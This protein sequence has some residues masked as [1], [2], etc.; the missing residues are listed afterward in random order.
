MEFVEFVWNSG[1]GPVPK[2]V[3]IYG[4]WDEYTDPISTIYDGHQRFHGKILL[5]MPG[6]FYYYFTVDG[7]EKRENDC[8]FKTVITNDTEVSFVSTNRVNVPK[9]TENSAV[10]TTNNPN[11]QRFAHFRTGVMASCKSLHSIKTDYHKLQNDAKNSMNTFQRSMEEDQRVTLSKLRDFMD[12]C[13]NLNSKY[14][15][16]VATNRKHFDKIQE[17]RG[18]IRVYARS[19]PILPIDGDS[20]HSVV[21]FMENQ[22]VEVQGKE[23]YNGAQGDG[24]RFEFDQIFDPQTNQ[25]T[26]YENVSGFVKSVMNGYNCCIFAYGQTGSGKTFTMQGTETNPGINIRALRQLFQIATERT[27]FEYTLSVNMMEIYNE[28]IRDLLVNEQ[29]NEQNDYKIRQKKNGGIYVE[30]LSTHQVESDQDVL[31]LMKLGMERRSVT[32]TKYNDA[33]SRSHSILTVTVIGKSALANATY[34]GK[35]H[36]I[37]LAGSEKVKKSGVDGVALKEAQNI[38]K[39]LSALGDVICALS[40]KAKHIPFRNSTLTHLLQDSLGGN[41]KALMFTNFSPAEAHQAETLNTL[42]FAQRVKTVELGT[43]KKNVSYSRSRSKGRKSMS[44]KSVARKSG[45]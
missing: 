27:E 35:L 15:K 16:A 8:A 40:K 11:T 25:D 22:M 30:N 33:S 17:L 43:S 32:A 41:S 26:V 42:K 2:E 5:P 21:R 37:D 1:D 12:Y 39:S 24:H 28:S 19:R 38:N 13:L 4:S 3:L 45:M 34:R 9:T 36:L 14:E 18:N 29:V 44:R 31:R 10:K 20:Q 23:R 7:E 6:N